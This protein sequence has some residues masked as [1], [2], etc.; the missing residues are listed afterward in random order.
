ML[1]IF[2]VYGYSIKKSSQHSIIWRW[3]VLCKKQDGG[4]IKICETF[5]GKSFKED[6]S[7]DTTFDPCY[8]LWDSPFKVFSFNLKS[9][10]KL[11]DI[12]HFIFR[13]YGLLRAGGNFI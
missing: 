10:L 2:F 1:K 8:F 9:I 6:L 12:L 5:S 11:L 3:A 7:I 13:T 4:R